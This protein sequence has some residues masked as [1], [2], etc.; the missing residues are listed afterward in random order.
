MYV[1][2]RKQVAA[3]PY[4]GLVNDC[5]YIA[6]ITLHSHTHVHA[7]TAVSTMQGNRSLGIEPTTFQLPDNRSTSWAT[8]PQKTSCIG[9]HAIRCYHRQGGEWDLKHFARQAWLI[10]WTNIDD[11]P[12]FMLP[13]WYIRVM[14]FFWFTI[15]FRYH[16]DI[17]LPLL[18]QMYS[19]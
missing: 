12:G 18:Q 2:F 9:L 16:S 15:T 19:L 17:W 8:A 3:T 1:G 6:K 11:L 7:P 4:K 13:E 10:L 5:I 14:G